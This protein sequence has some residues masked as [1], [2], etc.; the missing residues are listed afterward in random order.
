MTYFSIVTPVYGCQTSLYEL[1]LRLKQTLEPLNT[2]FEIIMVND[3][4]KDSSWE[5]IVELANKDPRVK[6]INLSRNFGQHN[7]ITAG[8][9]HCKGEWVV[10]MDCDLQDQ[11]EEIPKL[12]EKVC[13]GYEYVLASRNKRKDNIIRKF[14]SKIFYKVLNFLSDSKFDSSIANFG[15]YNYAVIKSI[16][17]LREKSRWFPTMV[18]WVGYKGTRILV[19]HAGRENGRSAYNVKKLSNL[20]LD[21][22]LL[23]SNK[24]LK[25]VI[26]LGLI[27]SFIAFFY[28]LIIIYRYFMGEVTVLG[29][30]SLIISIWF[31]AGVIIFIL[32]IIGLYIVKIYDHSKDRPLYI[33]KEK[34]NLQ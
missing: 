29:W 25:L 21:V 9:D 17:G 24:P 11:P 3:A 20:A 7:A 26:R 2:D 33:I 16:N 6:G 23:N 8:L 12:Y 32:G 34:T 1:Y 27:I 10:V 14:F 4:S 5:S 18:N 22:I 15:I 31:L 28:A 13:Q 19:H 30:T